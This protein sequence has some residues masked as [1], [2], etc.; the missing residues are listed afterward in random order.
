MS[1][2]T[3]ERFGAVRNR[4]TT[5]NFFSSLLFLSEGYP[6]PFGSDFGLWFFSLSLCVSI[7]T[8]EREK[9]RETFFFFPFWGERESRS[10]GKRTTDGEPHR[11]FFFSSSSSSPLLKGN[12]KSQLNGQSADEEKN[13]VLTPL[14]PTISHEY[15]ERGCRLRFCVN[16]VESCLQHCRLLHVRERATRTPEVPGKGEI[17]AGSHLLRLQ[18]CKTISRRNMGGIFNCRNRKTARNGS[19][20]CRT[21]AGNKKEKKFVDR[22]TSGWPTETELHVQPVTAEGWNAS[23]TCPVQIK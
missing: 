6:A 19:I 15:K 22:L 13:Q 17:R 20:D 18:G 1:T 9:R 16:D 5:A 12:E 11:I 14:T 23:F 21:D 3:R 7:V 2:E 4:M 8:H 10:R